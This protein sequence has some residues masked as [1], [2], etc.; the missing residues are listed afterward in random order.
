MS[1]AE[2]TDNDRFQ[3]WLMHMDDALDAF[4]AGLPEG[5]RAKLDY[6]IA[7]LDAIEA[8]LLA[9]HPS[10]ED[11]RKT[12]DPR[13]FDGC[14]RYVGETLRLR[15]GGKWAIVLDDPSNVHFRRPRVVNLRNG[16]APVCPLQWLFTAVSRRKGD[17]MRGIVMNF[18]LG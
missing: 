16:M 4:I 10:G 1:D 18:D 17:F 5:E 12:G 9:R 8:L 2:I 15:L 7:S 11:A 3:H 13:F 14:A 6:S